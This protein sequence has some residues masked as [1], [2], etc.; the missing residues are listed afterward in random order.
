MRLRKRSAE[1]CP[2]LRNRDFIAA[3]I[4]SSSFLGGFVSEWLFID[5][6]NIKWYLLALSFYMTI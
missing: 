5:G 4:L 1:H 3:V 2:L 6:Y